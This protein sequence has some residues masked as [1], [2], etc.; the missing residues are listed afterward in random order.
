[1]TSCCSF[2][3]GLVPTVQQSKNDTTYC[4]TASQTKRIAK[5]IAVQMDCDSISKEQDETINLLQKKGQKQD[6]SIANLEMKIMNLN[7]IEGNNTMNIFLL[8][9]TIEVQNK[10][11]KRS[12]FHKVLLSIGLGTVT[13][14]AIIK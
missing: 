12:K 4:F 11:L 7:Q 5:I 13:T 2:S 1:M 6:S 8:E 3:Q 9:K 14:I 10:L